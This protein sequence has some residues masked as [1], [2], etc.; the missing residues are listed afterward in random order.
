M[1]PAL[2]GLRFW[3]AYLPA[4][5]GTP[6]VSVPSL[7]KSWPRPVPSFGN[8][9][10]SCSTFETSV[11]Y[12]WICEHSAVTGASSLRGGR[13]NWKELGRAVSRKARACRW[14]E[15]HRKCPSWAQA[16]SGLTTGSLLILN[17]VC[18]NTCAGVCALH[19]PSLLLLSLMLGHFTCRLPLTALEL[20]PCGV[21]CRQKDFGGQRHHQVCL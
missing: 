4:T 9:P 13:R 21:T 6:A 5:V 15:Q 16:A 18:E 19:S 3:V 20:T 2:R 17:S 14:T 12:W 8:F 11:T 1:W 7:L 10:S